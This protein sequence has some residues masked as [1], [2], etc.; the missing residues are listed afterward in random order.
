MS[1]VLD[2]PAPVDE[3]AVTTAR[4]TDYDAYVAKG[5]PRDVECPGWTSAEFAVDN[6][7]GSLTVRIEP[8]RLSD[9][10][11]SVAVEM[12]HEK[13]WL[14]MI[15]AQYKGPFGAKDEIS[16]SCSQARFA[17][18]LCRVVVVADKPESIAIKV[19]HS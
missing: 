5:D 16:L 7:D 9:A 10:A 13:A 11:F 2:K 4:K 3:V 18:N 15:R 8:D 6:R 17:G 1:A 19:E 12:M 14:R